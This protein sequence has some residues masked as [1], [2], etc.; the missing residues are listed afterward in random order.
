MTHEQAMQVV[1]RDH[2]LN[3]TQGGSYVIEA[4]R[5][6]GYQVRWLSPEGESFTVSYELTREAWGLPG[7]F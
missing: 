5:E 6:G 4:A 7:E 1:V 2:V 3:P